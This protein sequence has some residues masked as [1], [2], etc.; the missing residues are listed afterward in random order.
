[1]FDCRMNAEPSVGKL[2][3]V[4]NHY[5]LARPATVSSLMLKLGTDE[6]GNVTF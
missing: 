1:M 6:V 2:I 3:A 5:S 4:R